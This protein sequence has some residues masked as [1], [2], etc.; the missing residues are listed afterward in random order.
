[1]ALFREKGFGGTSVRDLE[2]AT[3]LKAASLHNA[4]GNKNALF[5]AAMDHHCTT[6]VRDRIDR[7]L[8][9]G[10]GLDGLRAFF[11]S[12]YAPDHRLRHHR[13]QRDRLHRES[14]E[15]KREERDILT[16][17]NARAIWDSYTASWSATEDESRLALFRDCLTDDCVYKDPNIGTHGYEELAAY[18]TG[19]QQQTPGASFVTREFVSH[20]DS[21]LIR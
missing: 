8:R 1:M 11:A 5:A 18:M 12:T 13:R 3:T 7:H 14:I 17:V 19:L 2:A 10:L 4:F 6:V 15:T 21:A 16:S 20:H 9:P